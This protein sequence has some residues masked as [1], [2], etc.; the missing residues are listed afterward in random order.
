[1]KSKEAGGLVN[2]LA[3][4]GGDVITLDEELGLAQ[5]VLPEILKD[6]P[7]LNDPEVQ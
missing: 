3:R 5:Q 6:Y 2:G 1:M 4:S 7:R